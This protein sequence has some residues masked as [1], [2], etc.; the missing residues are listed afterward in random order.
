MKAKREEMQE[1]MELARWEKYMDACMNPYLKRKPDSPR[2][3]VRFEWEKPEGGGVPLKCT[4]EE[5]Q[6]LNAIFRNLNNNGN[7][8]DR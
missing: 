7:G 8:K 6:A 4:D 5:A 1:R 3:L 2:A